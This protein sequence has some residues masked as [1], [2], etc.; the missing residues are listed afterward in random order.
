MKLF[1][2][3]PVLALAALGLAVASLTGCGGAA[4]GGTDTTLDVQF[5]GPPITGLDPAKSGGGGSLIYNTLAYDS[6]IFM[7]PDGTLVPD[8]AES[9][10]WADDQHR[11]F[12][13]TLRTGVKFS[14]GTEMTAEGVA[15]WLRYFKDAKSTL[16]GTLAMLTEAA[17]VDATTVRMT[18]SEPSPDLPVLLSQ[19]FPGGLVAAPAGMNT[20]GSLDAAT[21]GT[22]P[23]MLDPA[24]TVTGDHYTYV[25]NPHYWNPNGIVYEKV[26]VHTI[27]DANTVLSALSSGQLDIA[28]GSP[29]TARAAEDSGI[30]VRSAPGRVV[31]LF[32]LDRDGTH[33]PALADVKVRQAINYAIDRASIVAA[34]NP[35]GFADPTSQMAVPQQEGF[36]PALDTIYPYDPVKARQL[37]A[38]AGFG[39]GFTFEVTCSSTLGTCPYAETVANSLADVGITMTIDQQ[40][41]VSAFNQKFASGGAPAVLFQSGGPAYRTAYGLTRKNVLAN[42]FNTEDADVEAAFRQLTAGDAVGPAWRDLVRLL[43]EKG[44][45]A[46]VARPHALVFSTGVGNVSLH[47]KVPTY[48]SVIDPTGTHTWRPA[49]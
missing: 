20:P 38:E 27:S 29:S 33:V 1:R 30:E 44:W 24:D 13:L 23:Y 15:Q 19:Q 37:L 40:S 10:R 47:E 9:W 4:A 18:L 26:V 25:P 48:F 22:G 46:P 5:S 21:I 42:P 43:A 39:G 12:E 3:R 28:L 36:D 16:S 41:E 2:S 34:L 7:Q 8:L 14:D 11:V 35:D 32:L 6:L 31:G 17:A 49:A 45:F